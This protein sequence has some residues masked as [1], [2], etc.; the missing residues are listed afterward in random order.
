MAFAIHAE[1]AGDDAAYHAVL[2]DQRFL[3]GEA[4]V[5]LDAQAFGLLG[6]PAAQV[7]QGDDVVALVVHGLGHEEVG[8]LDRAFGILEHIDVVAL[9]RGVQ[10]GAEFLPVREQLVQR[11]R[12]EHGTREDVGADFGTFS[13]THTL[14][15]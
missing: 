15:S 4:R 7:A 5:D 9:D 11:T 2:V 6:Q 13:T 12:L 10:R 8:D 3:G 14:I 1:V